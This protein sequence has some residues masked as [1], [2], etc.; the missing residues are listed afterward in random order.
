VSEPTGL[1]RLD[2]DRTELMK[3]HPGWRIWFVPNALDGSVTWCAQP[4][5]TIHTYSPEDLSKDI[6]LAEEDLAGRLAREA[7]TAGRR[8]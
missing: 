4:E 3:Q 8:A 7:G 6:R 2:R 5:P 1:A